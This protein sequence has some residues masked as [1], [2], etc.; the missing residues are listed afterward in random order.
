MGY[1]QVT[2]EVDLAL[3]TLYAFWVFFA[4][5]IFYLRR[6]DRREGYP[7]EADTT[8]QVENPGVIWVPSPKTF[9]M[10][11]GSTV[12]APR[13][14]RDSRDIAA[15]PIA[16]WP[17]AP[18]EPTGD[19]MLDAVGPAAYAQRKDVPDVTMEGDLKIAPLRSLPEF[20]IV[21][22][23]PDPRGMAVIG[24]DRGVGGTVKDVWIDRAE[25]LIRY[26]EVELPPAGEGAPP[27]RTVLLPMP[28]AKI[29]GRRRRVHV[30]AITGAQFANVPALRSPDQV[31]FLEED[32]ISAYYG[33]GL[34]FSHPLRR[35]SL[36]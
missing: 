27:G 15:R 16:P 26:L 25:V 6:E 33:G 3:I 20:G 1:G 19:P 5:L 8:G 17:G 31:T 18:L 24:T 22:R 7:L 34:L 35:E 4:L 11:D 13:D 28:F 36:L 29:D 12:T 21:G 10:R 2:S 30:N 32:R 14:A 9:H 23:D